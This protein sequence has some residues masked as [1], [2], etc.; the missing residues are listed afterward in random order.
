[1]RHQPEGLEQLQAQTKFTKKEL[2]SLYRGFKSV[3]AWG[4]VSGS[5]RGPVGLTWRPFCPPPGVPQRPGGQGDLHAH[6][7]AVLPAGR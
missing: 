6:L 3:S 5:G 7:R 1:M 4:R 2:Q